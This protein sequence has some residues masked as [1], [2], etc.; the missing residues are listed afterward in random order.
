MNEPVAES[1]SSFDRAVRAHDRK[2]EELG[3]EL[4]LGSE[5]TFTDRYSGEPQWLGD[6][7]GGPSAVSIPTRPHRAGTSEFI[8]AA[9]AFR[10]GLALPIPSSATR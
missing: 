5:P 7:L 8:R 10:S 3:L 1:E 9:T 6:A 2:L 4:W